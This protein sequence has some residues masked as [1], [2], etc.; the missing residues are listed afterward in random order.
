LRRIR[1][2]IAGN[3]NGHLHDGGTRF[4]MELLGRLARRGHDVGI[5]VTSPRERGPEYLLSA[6]REWGADIR[7]IK[8]D[9]ATIILQGIPIRFWFTDLDIFGV[10]RSGDMDATKKIQRFVRKAV[11]RFP[12]SLAITTQEDVFSL[13]AVLAGEIPSAHFRSVSEG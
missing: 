7:K 13:G 4:F 10:Y 11:F 9:R 2:L 5:E 1:L 3:F 6:A 8:A 12:P